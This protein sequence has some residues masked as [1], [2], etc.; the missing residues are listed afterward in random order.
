MY[1]RFSFGILFQENIQLNPFCGYK[2]NRIG[3]LVLLSEFYQ[4]Q[5]VILG[6]DLWS[7]PSALYI[8]LFKG[9]GY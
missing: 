3:P 1:L 8:P 4:T 2:E 6:A 5:P 9:Q 7:F